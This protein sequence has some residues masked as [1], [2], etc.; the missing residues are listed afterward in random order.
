DLPRGAGAVQD[1]AADEVL[2]V[3]CDLGGRACRASDD[4]LSQ[5]RGEALDV[6]DDCGLGITG[7]AGRHV[8]VGPH[9]VDV[10]GRALGV[11]QV[12]LPD[13]HERPLRHAAA[14]DRALGGHDL[15]ERTA[16]VYG[17]RASARLVG[18]GHAALD[19]QVEL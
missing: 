12:L 10:A 1:V 18:P 3:G 14:V 9:R 8:G 7:E 5:A 19:G 13:Q 16:H 11:G 17:A 15:L 4:A 2:V 6:I